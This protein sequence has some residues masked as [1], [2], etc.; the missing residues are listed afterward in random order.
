M[1]TLLKKVLQ[2]NVL[3]D[4]SE[5]RFWNTLKLDSDT[6]N[7]NEKNYIAA[8]V[9]PMFDPRVNVYNK[10]GSLTGIRYVK[11][12]AGRLSPPIFRGGYTKGPEVLIAIFM[13]DISDDPDV[14]DE[15]SDDAVAKAVAA[16]KNVAKEV[17]NQYYASN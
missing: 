2:D 1:V 13:D 7:V 5:T 12:D 10:P 4:T 15:A 6:N 16:I 8:Q 3:S 9:T 14:M 11:A 17:A